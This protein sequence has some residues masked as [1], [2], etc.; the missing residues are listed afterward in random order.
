MFKLTSSDF[1]HMFKWV[2][3]YF[4]PKFLKIKGEVIYCPEL[5]AE[6]K[7]FLK[8]KQIKV[9]KVLPNV[10]SLTPETF[11]S[12]FYWDDK[13][14]NPN[15]LIWHSKDE[16]MSIVQERE[17]ETELRL[18]TEGKSCLLPCEGANLYSIVFLNW[19]YIKDE[20]SSH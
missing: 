8:N 9:T 6:Q 15:K 17:G 11:T 7:E 2:T 3:F 10:S 12:L 16:N 19:E 4:N 1:C 18:H 13:N 20:I 5:T 14:L